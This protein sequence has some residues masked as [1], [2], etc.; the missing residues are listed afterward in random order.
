MIP[1]LIIVFG[2]SAARTVGSSVFIAMILT[3]ITALVYGK[4]GA[5]DAPTA[6]VM[7]AGS[8]GGVR[9]GTKLS[10]KLPDQLLRLVMIGLILI[11]AVMMLINR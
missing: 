2:L 6:V 1:L 10:V 9:Y 8:L 11:A 5:L 4:D 3:L 7:A